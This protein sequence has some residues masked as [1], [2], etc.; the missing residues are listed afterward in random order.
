[1]PLKKD[2]GQWISHFKDSD[3]PQFRGKSEE[4]RKNM[5]L[6]AFRKKYGSAL[7]EASKEEETKFHKK[8]DTLVHSTFGKRKG[9]LEEKAG[10]KQNEAAKPD[11]LDVDKDGDKKETMKKALTDKAMKKVKEVVVTD[12]AEKAEDIANKTGEEVKVVK[13]GTI[14]EGREY[15][16]EGKMAQAQLLSIVKN[17]RDL[18]NMIGKDDQLKSWVQ[19]KLT[20]AEDYLDSVRTYLEGESLTTTAPVVVQEDRVKDEEGTNLNIGDVVKAGDGRIYQIIFSYS[21]N[22]PFLV[23]F[24][25]KKRKPTTLRSKV[26]FDSEDLIT[27]KLNKIMDYS[28]TKGGFMK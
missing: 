11:F 4:Q 23:P 16:Y 26:Y 6:A 22:K 28:A 5:A 13:K 17:S 14:Q 20:K 1:M 12:D 25:L 24:D 7:E 21:E 10:Q 3:A 9:G 15:D 27:K 8:L 18:F 2:L 19:S